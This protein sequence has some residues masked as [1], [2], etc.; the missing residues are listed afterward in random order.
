[1]TTIRCTGGS[2]FRIQPNPPVAG[3]KLEVTYI[4]PADV[5]EYQVD[6]ETSVRVTPDANGKFTIDP[7]PAG[8]ELMLTDNLGQPG[9]LHAEI[10]QA[11]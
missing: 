6:D 9:Y 11:I 3:K 5:V 2:R 10:V 1:M 8:D 7:L 4:G